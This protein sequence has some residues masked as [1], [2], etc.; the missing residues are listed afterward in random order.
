MQ[1]EFT[2]LWIP[3]VTP[4][5]DGGVDLPALRR[6]ATHCAQAGV[7]G[8]VA[9]GS[10]GEAAA[11]DDDEQA[12][13]L[14]TVLAAGG[15]KPV[16]MG[17]A[18]CHLGKTRDRLLQL[19]E[20]FAARTPFAGFL[21]PAP[22]YVRPSQQGLLDWC[23]TLADASPLPLVLYDIPYRTGVE[24]NLA[25]LRTLAAHP[26]IRGVKDCAGD[27]AKTRALVGDGRLA[28][29]AGNDAESFGTLCVGGAG[30]IAA[31]A[32]V[33]P[34]AHV[35][36]HRALREQR[37]ADARVLWQRIA[38]VIALL[39]RE[40]NP[41][42]LKAWLAHAGWMADELRVPMTRCTPA[43]REELVTAAARLAQA[44]GAPA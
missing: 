39:F 33:H 35:A 20:R 15:G 3:L 19:A 36:L 37:L 14:D 4:F 21:V 30:A 7:D 32:M 16:L 22:Y 43:L 29:L 44:P 18:G 41:G 2:G 9:C 40:P 34:A 27:P 13:V 23:G 10:T 8:F 26:R 6:L 42:P 25:T 17:L 24:I 31:S 12:A 5:R 1:T 38:P 11:L 28:V